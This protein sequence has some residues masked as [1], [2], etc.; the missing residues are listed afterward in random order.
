MIWFTLYKFHRDESG[1]HSVRVSQNWRLAKWN[2]R[3]RCDVG[4]IGEDGRPSKILETW[5]RETWWKWRLDDVRGL[6][7]KRTTETQTLLTQ[8][9]TTPFTNRHPVAGEGRFGVEVMTGEEGRRSGLWTCVCGT[10]LGNAQGTV[11]RTLAV[12]TKMEKI[13]VAIY[14]FT[15]PMALSFFVLLCDFPWPTANVESGQTRPI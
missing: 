6:E 8:W 12:Q 1:E 7:H 15:Y 10:P 5:E 4:R 2:T 13:M 9:V 14:L 11:G 3:G